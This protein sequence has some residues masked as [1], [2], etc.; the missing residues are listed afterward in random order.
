MTQNLLVILV[1]Y[2]VS[3]SA[4]CN[5]I[6]IFGAEDYPVICF[7]ENG[8]PQGIFPQILSGVS[9]FSGD[10]YELQLLPWKRA[11]AFAEEGKGGIAHFSKSTER[12]DKFDYSNVVYGDRIQLVVLRDHVFPFNGLSDLNGKQIGVKFG[13]SF[14]QNIDSYLA[15]NL[16]HT[17]TDPGV[18]SRLRKLLINRIDVAIVEGADNDIDKLIGQDAD[19]QKHKMQFVFLSVPL[20]DDELYLAFAKT[21]KRKNVIER[22]N[23]GLEKF[24][25][26]D[27]YKKILSGHPS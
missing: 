13:A 17:Q 7:L 14:G 9:K 24:M 5:T 27:L 3:G 18:I 16:V 12:E 25:K 15:S 4:W 20:V 19:L 22:F 2:F 21:M 23:Q 1:C 6:P 8:K 11:Q 10:T 26:T